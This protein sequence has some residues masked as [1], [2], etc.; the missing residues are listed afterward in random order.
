M[1]KWQ[2][3][4]DYINEL[5]VGYIITRREIIPQQG[6]SDSVDL[7]RKGLCDLGILTM[8]GRGKYVKN[9]D[10][11]A[12]VNSNNYRDPKLKEQLDLINKFKIL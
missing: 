12:V 11:P 6:Y 8:V 5:P 10:V 1:S 9:S 4:I 2:K 7:Y 3:L